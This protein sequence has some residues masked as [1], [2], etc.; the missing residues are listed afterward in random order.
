MGGQEAGI[1]QTESSGRILT[2]AWAT[3]FLVTGLALAL[4]APNQTL[5]RLSLGLGL[6]GVFIF[7]LYLFVIRRRTVTVLRSGKSKNQLFLVLVF[8]MFLAWFVGALGSIIQSVFQLIVGIVIG[9]L[10][11]LI[12]LVLWLKRR[13]RPE[14]MT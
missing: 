1:P 12:L 14:L 10:F 7:A 8:L 13:I 9:T 4:T 5:K 6:L 2:L 11:F 3:L